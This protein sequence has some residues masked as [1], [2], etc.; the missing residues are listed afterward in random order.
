MAVAVHRARQPRWEKHITLGLFLQVKMK[1]VLTK[2][3]LKGKI[4]LKI[5]LS[6]AM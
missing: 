5:T 1:A 4:G 6:P 3:L 2:Q